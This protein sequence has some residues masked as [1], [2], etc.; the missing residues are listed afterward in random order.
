M[1][2]DEV[3]KLS[4]EGFNCAQIV[5][6]A[7]SEELNVDKDTAKK[8]AACFGGGMGCGATCGAYTGALMVIGL[9]YGNSLPNDAESRKKAKEKAE[10]FKELFLEEYESMEC[11]DLLGYDVSN[12]KDLE[13]IQQKGLFTTFCSDLIAYTTEILKEVL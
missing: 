3:N 1:N 4:S 13:I 6:A 9:K 2:V 7:F 12:P 8:M 10:K 5:A 11:K